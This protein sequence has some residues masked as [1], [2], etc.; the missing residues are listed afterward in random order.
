MAGYVK[1]YG[2]HLM[3]KE[4]YF[5]YRNLL[6]EEITFLCSSEVFIFINSDAIWNYDESDF[7]VSK[8]VE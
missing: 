7:N 1:W 4:L 3:L 8:L 2:M 5:F 6:P